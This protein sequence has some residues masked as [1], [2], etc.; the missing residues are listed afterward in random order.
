LPVRF[1]L[2]VG[3]II[4][5]RL[6]LWAVL[7]LSGLD[8]ATRN[9]PK[10]A[11][12]RKAILDASEILF[13][14]HGYQGTGLRDIA[15]QAGVR[16]SLV[17]Y[18][19]GNKHEIFSAV[20][21]RKLGMLVEIIAQSFADADAVSPAGLDIEQTVAAFVLPFL[22]VA[23]TPDHDL[24]HYVIMTSH[25]MSSYRMPELRPVLQ[26]LSAVSALFEERVR[27]LT[28]DAQASDILAAIYL[29]ESALIFMVQDPGF[30]DDLTRDHHSV[31]GLEDMARPAI[32]FFSAG[33]ERL[34]KPH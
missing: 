31:G 33:L 27:V 23:A 26:K 13:A 14:R 22:A 9:S 3:A 20:V 8:M 17:H 30:L 2:M 28:P 7:R 32:R 12:T 5:L 15:A 1:V 18:H 21:D 6:L 19:F 11:E 10:G 4:Q 25:L 24:R 29:I 16:Q 34:T